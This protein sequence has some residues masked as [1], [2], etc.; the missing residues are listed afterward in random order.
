MEKKRQHMTEADL[1]K[2]P[3]DRRSKRL[4]TVFDAITR[5]HYTVH[6]NAVTII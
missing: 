3:F 2:L 6:S 5:R 4:A 1:C